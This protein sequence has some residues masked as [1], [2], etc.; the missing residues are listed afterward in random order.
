VP[1]LETY[2]FWLLLA[3]G[4]LGAVGS[5]WLIVQ[6]FRAGVW[7]GLG[8]LVFPP[9]ALVF[10]PMR[11]GFA[12][13][14]VALMLVAGVAAAGGLVT[15]QVFQP[16]RDP[17]V[18]IVDG[19][20]HVTLTRVVVDDYSFLANYPDVVVLQMANK[21]VTDVTLKHISGMTKLR[22]LDLSDTKVTDEGLA[23][24]AKLPKLETLRL[25]GTAVTAEGF[26][27]H[28]SGLPS[29]TQVDLSNCP[30]ISSLKKEEKAKWR[31]AKE[32]FREA[33]KD[34][35]PRILDQ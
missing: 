32:A 12:R 34:K 35:D 18:K 26:E 6:A 31:K 7:W 22:E 3:A 11:W 23:E 17:R 25:A 29:L 28:L 20:Q 27:K 21:D 2:I 8:V 10:V 4:V 1:H 30:A 13:G 14:P 15:A 16:S 33:R 9:T 24:L 19:E 5:I